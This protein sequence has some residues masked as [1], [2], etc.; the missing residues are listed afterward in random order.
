MTNSDHR[1]IVGGIF[2]YF[3][4]P[5]SATLHDEIDFEL[6]T[7]A[8]GRIQTNV[9]ADEPLGDGHP[10]SIPYASGSIADWHTYEIKW[11]PGRVSWIVDGVAVRTTTSNVPTHP[12]NFYLNAWVPDHWWPLAYSE[13]IQPAASKE[14]N[15]VL[16]SLCVDRVVV[17]PL[18]P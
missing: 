2:F 12:M 16:D 8:P 9:Y 4:E 15:V 18:P 11:V 3:L 17:R 1:G 10:Q 14:S 13:S 7:N 6:L 5:G